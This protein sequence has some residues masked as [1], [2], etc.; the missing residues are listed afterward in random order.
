MTA[1]ISPYALTTL[2]A[3]KQA[4]GIDV[5]EHDEMIARL[6]N[7]ASGAIEAYCSRRLVSRVYAA[8]TTGPP[9]TPDTRLV[10]DGHGGDVGL[11]PEHPVTALVGAWSVLE[12][13][14]TAID[15]TGARVESWGRI[16][17][18][19]DFFEA[20]SGNILLAATCGYLAGTHDFDLD[21]LAQA[22]ERTVVVWYQDWRNKIGRGTEVM[23]GGA[24]VRTMEGAMPKDVTDMLQ[25]YV[26]GDV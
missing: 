6:V 11:I 17:L 1:I 8:A 26:R 4:I 16:C 15:I 18:A 21:V 7:R 13:V 14:E 22:C 19:N 12:G 2:S 23:S 20:G 10:M 5:A 25:P 24:V 9:P 3:A